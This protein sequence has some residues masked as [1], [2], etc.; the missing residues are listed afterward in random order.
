M[1]SEALCRM[2]H[3]FLVLTMQVEGD[4]AMYGCQAVAGYCLFQGSS[5]LMFFKDC[6]HSNDSHSSFRADGIVVEAVP[7]Y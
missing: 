7:N 2:Y 5:L 4:I 3:L 1:H 6:N